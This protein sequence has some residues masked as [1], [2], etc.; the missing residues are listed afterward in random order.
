M[1]KLLTALSFCLLASVQLAAQNKS[2]IDDFSKAPSGWS[3]WQPGDKSFS[4]SKDE[5]NKFNEK[6]SMLIDMKSGSGVIQRALAASESCSGI[7]L[8]LKSADGNS[9]HKLT[10]HLVEESGEIYYTDLVV[11]EKWTVSVLPFSSF[12]LWPYGNATIKE[13]KLEP[14]KLR[15][16]KFYAD[17]KR[18]NAVFNI[19]MMEFI[20]TDGAKAPE[21][22]ENKRTLIIEDVVMDNA[23]PRAS[24][25]ELPESSH[26]VT[27]KDGS[28]YRNGQPEFLIGGWQIDNE[29]HPWLMRLLKMDFYPYNATE[30]Y[31]QYG[32][33]VKDGKIIVSKAPAPWYEAWIYRAVSNGLLFWQEHK[34]EAKYCALKKELPDLI[35]AG[36]FVCYDPLVPEGQKLYDTMFKSWM[37]YTRKYPVFC[38]EL[39]N[40]VMYSNNKESAIKDFR[41]RMK[42][43]Y[44]D[45]KVA[46]AAWGTEFKSFDEV[47]P[48][49]KIS[50]ATDA[51]LGGSAAVE[52]EKR[53]ARIYNNLWVDWI[54]TQEEQFGT[55]MKDMMKSMRAHDPRPGILNTVQSHSN[56]AWDY[57]N[58]GVNP[59][60][61]AAA[62]DF[63]THEA[64]LGIS[65]Q[66]QENDQT[67]IKSM[68]TLGMTCDVVRG[69]CKG[70][71]ALNGESPLHVNNSVMSEERLVK[72]DIGSMQTGWKF[73]D[74][75][76]ASPENWMS[77]S[78]DDSSWTSVKVPE[79]W[80]R[81]GFAKCSTGI[82]RKTFTP[83]KKAEKYYLNGK[84]FCDNA[85]I[86][87]NGQLIH[88][89]KLWNE[90]FCLD[91]TS[92]IKKEN[93]LAAKIT[94]KYFKD[95]M[96]YGGIR[97]YVSVTDRPSVRNTTVKPSYIRTHIWSQL[98]HGMSGDMICYTSTGFQDGIK[99]VPQT[100]QEISSVA[101]IVMPRSKMKSNIA[102]VYPFE[103]FRSFY[104]DSY[105]EYLKAPLTKALMDH[106]S[107]LLSNSADFD[108]IS[109]QDIAAGM[110]SSY[111]MI[112]C[113]Q[114]IRI[115]AE[116]LKTLNAYV[117]NGGILLSEMDSMS[118]NDET[119]S[120]MSDAFE[121]QPVSLVRKETSPVSL[122]DSELSPRRLDEI[123]YMEF[124][125]KADS[126][127]LS[128]FTNGKA[129]VVKGSYGKGSVYS[130][131]AQLPY[132]E[133]KKLYSS[134]MDEYKIPTCTSVRSENGSI[135]DFVETR[136]FSDKQKHVLAAINWG[137]DGSYIVKFNSIPD[138][139]YSIRKIIS[140]E[141]IANG[142]GSKTWK[143]SD[144]R[145]GIKLPLR[146]LDPLVLL[147][148]D[149]KNPPLKIKGISPARYQMLASLWPDEKSSG[150]LKIAITPEIDELTSNPLPN[151]YIPTTEK[152]L[153]SAGY[154]LVK[155]SPGQSLEG[156]K[157]LLWTCP[158][159]KLNDT[160]TEIIRKF[161][162]DGGS[163]M[164]F[165]RG[166]A[167][168]HTMLKAAS[169]LWNTFGFSTDIGFNYLWTNSPEAGFDFLQISCPVQSDDPA[170]Y[171]VKTFMSSYAGYLPIKDKSKFKI[172]MTAPA[173]TNLTGEV[174]MAET[175]YGQGRVIAIADSYFL[176]PLNIELAD[177]AQLLVSAVNS[178][179]GKAP[180]LLT[181][182]QK[183]NS[184]F[185]SR[186]SLS[187]AEKEEAEGKYEFRS[188]KIQGKSSTLMK[189][190][191]DRKDPIVDMQD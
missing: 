21:K 166:A 168:Y 8:A 125:A 84:D 93:V 167:N 12:K 111:K 191:S 45:I 62:V 48:P 151:S 159:T 98:M 15:T 75:T 57:V 13:G 143:G 119:H 136:L 142:E 176:K 82:Y 52:L 40:E 157:T 5:N 132:D 70:K 2:L 161:V 171:G 27:I 79:M 184:L 158:N 135:P 137:I 188:L 80:G 39:F 102:L 71:P 42:A 41:V 47:Q 131:A 183:K 105:H 49:G 53:Q 37:Q 31:I 11:P 58:I 185:I 28:F 87:I 85:E 95:E 29:C 127:I 155:Y 76:Q 190:S 36:H 101:S 116:A 124:S 148:E 120:I 54:K 169:K 165:G 170:L 90:K 118:V 64:G 22:Q 23:P 51:G 14:S 134:I 63:Y 189:Q 130:L 16:F 177:N 81:Q 147:V 149:V 113:A 18:G 123:S 121:F 160:Q 4:F 46:N 163:L 6:P 122:G 44:K 69:A 152:L 146:N 78:F 86:Y 66:E 38:Y 73:F 100:K 91:I 139:E 129:A 56:L 61:L 60:K 133:L 138:G 114:N 97:G 164:L 128:S 10:I 156:V 68:L 24:F 126:K 187:A 83:S 96:F 32:P 17:G 26:N 19:A 3:V 141:L 150:G 173:G 88:T 180:A 112:I 106:Y 179:S 1:R 175:K 25:T 117:K 65:P 153:E 182:S 109:N 107:A 20:L 181:E 154:E 94:N 9:G 55:V 144:L 108:L 77:P 186:E 74:A 33:V 174:L 50:I 104:H 145:K 89:T 162:E 92:Y 178:L 7:S 30:I 172:L 35:D 103:T 34:A 115:S 140:N 43:K 59:A 72:S 67:Q 99:I 110:A